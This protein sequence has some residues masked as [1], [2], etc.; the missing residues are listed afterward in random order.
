MFQLH[1]LVVSSLILLIVVIASA[2][3]TKADSVTLTL[4]NPTQTGAIGST[5]LFTGILTNTGTESVLID[6]SSL[7]VDPFTTTRNL[8]FTSGALTLA[9][10]QSTGE[11]LLFTVTLDPALN[12]RS[13]IA[14][15]FSV[16]RSST[17]GGTLATQ[18]FS[19]NVEPVPEPA[20]LLLL[21]SGLVAIA[22]TARRRSRY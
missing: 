9:P 1:K 8:I 16:G 11:I 7:I 3:R 18:E 17:A 6:S 22:S 4:T 19:I 5:L 20:T 10:M 15:F 21:G 12:A 14:G 2:D 13:T